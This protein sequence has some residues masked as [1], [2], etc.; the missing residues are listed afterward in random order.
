MTDATDLWV[1]GYGSLMW[2]PDIPFVERHVA[3]VAG[4]HRAFC[5]A[6]THHRGTEARP[7]LVLGLDRGGSCTGIAYRIADDERRATLDYLRERELIYGVYRA[8]RITVRLHADDHLDVP[9]LA[10]VVERAHPSY[11]GGLAPQ[12]QV[13]LIRQARGISGNNL[14]YLINTVNQL[15]ALGIRERRLERLVALAAGPAKRGSPSETIRPAVGAI[16]AAWALRPVPSR[17]LPRD[18][19]RRFCYRWRI[20]SH[21]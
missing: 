18:Q 19:R 13:R 15:S 11:L 5:V 10:Y 6:S 17:Q 12:Q 3:T 2:R 1:F 8:A 7:G 14:D 4:L 9:A 21:G 16:R 20:G